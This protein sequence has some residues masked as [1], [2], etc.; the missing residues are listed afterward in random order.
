MVANCIDDKNLML[1]K[2]LRKK[3]R[4]YTHLNLK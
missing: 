3:N 4:K 1:S 2:N